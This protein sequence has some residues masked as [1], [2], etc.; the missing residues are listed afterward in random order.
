MNSSHFLD[1]PDA[2]INEHSFDQLHQEIEKLARVRG[3]TPVDMLNLP[4]LLN[5]AFDKIMK[6]G[7]VTLSEFATV[8]VF[9]ESQAEQL[10]TLLIRKGYLRVTDEAT[11]SEPAYQIRFANK[12]KRRIPSNIWQ[13]L[14]S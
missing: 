4:S 1:K 2:T 8:L 7:L 12:R 6:R 5:L 9:T 14:E 13:A 11:L 10:A 3:I